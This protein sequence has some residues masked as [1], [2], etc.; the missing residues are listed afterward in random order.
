MV[1][2]HIKIYSAIVLLF[3]LISCTSISN[4]EMACN[5]VDGAVNSED[6]GVFNTIFNGTINSLFSDSESDCVNREQSACIDSEGDI[7]D[8][9]VTTE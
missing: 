1:I 6:S 9:C 8:E 2:R 7:K 4:E 3:T 5:F